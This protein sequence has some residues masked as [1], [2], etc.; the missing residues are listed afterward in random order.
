MGF[1]SDKIEQSMIV[2]GLVDPLPGTHQYVLKRYFESIRDANNELIRRI[3]VWYQNDKPHAD[4]LDENAE[5]R[6][7]I[8]VLESELNVLKFLRSN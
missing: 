3:N 1:D 5:L 6:K 2:I 8:Q 4:L 7:R